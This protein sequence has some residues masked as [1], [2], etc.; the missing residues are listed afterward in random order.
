MGRCDFGLN[1]CPSEGKKKQ[2]YRYDRTEQAVQAQKAKVCAKDQVCRT[3]E[4]SLGVLVSGNGNAARSNKRWQFMDGG[5]ELQVEVW[6][7]NSVFVPDGLGVISLARVLY[8]TIQ[9]LGKLDLG[10]RCRGWKH[11]PFAEAIVF[12]LRNQFCSLQFKH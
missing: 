12:I 3:L 1:F 6:R 8:G 10:T 11:E 7:G 2:T 5:A 9:E 4:I